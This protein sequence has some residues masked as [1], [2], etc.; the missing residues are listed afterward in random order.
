MVLAQAM[1]DYD[2]L[3]SEPRL[4]RCVEAIELC[5]SAEHNFGLGAPFDLYLKRIQAFQESAPPADWTENFCRGD[6]VGYFVA[7]FDA[8]RLR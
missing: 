7:G 5:R 3:L 2:L 1:V 4:G 6:E 8:T